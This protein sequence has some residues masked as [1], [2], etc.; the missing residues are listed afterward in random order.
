M[1]KVAVVFAGLTA[2]ASAGVVAPPADQDI[3][4]TAIAAGSFKTLV[5]AAQAA[6]PRR[7]AH[8]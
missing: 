8:L 3:V 1:K 5:K 6:R 4:G 2:F 7:D